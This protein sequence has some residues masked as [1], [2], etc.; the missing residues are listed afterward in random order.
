MWKEAKQALNNRVCIRSILLYTSGV[1]CYQKI[2]V[3]SLTFFDC[4]LC[5]H[6]CSLKF[7]I[8]ITQQRPLPWQVYSK[9]WILV[10][11]SLSCSFVQWI[12]LLLPLNMTKAGVAWKYSEYIF[13][14]SNMS[15][16][17]RFIY[18][19]KACSRPTGF[20]SLHCLLCRS[21]ALVVRGHSSKCCRSMFVKGWH[22]IL[23]WFAQ[24][25][26]L[27][28]WFADFQLFDPLSSISTWWDPRPGTRALTSQTLS[29]QHRHLKSLYTWSWVLALVIAAETRW[30][31]CLSICRFAG[32]WCLHTFSL[33]RW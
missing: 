8:G 29:S 23:R 25:H 30:N 32:W 1:L 13:G 33:T 18:S 15:Q 6:R 9:V 10:W 24:V 4:L 22:S 26:Q 12:C 11:W 3:C 28:Q 5:F 16:C 20:C 14:G 21:T 31:A 17:Y 19:I 27:T 2:F 7:I